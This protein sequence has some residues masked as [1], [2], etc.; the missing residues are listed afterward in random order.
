MS[1]V[2]ENQSSRERSWIYIVSCVVLGLVVLAAVLFFSAAR[3][4]TKA[5]NKADE[6]IAALDQAGARTPDRDQ[7]VRVLGDDGGATCADPNKALSRATLLA[8]L[9]NGATGPG[10]RPVIADS[11][12]VKGQLLIIQVYCPDELQ[13]FQKFADDLETD[14]VAG[15]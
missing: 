8:L 2:T 3:E 11:R 5:Q 10:A 12:A 6:L 4:T 1:T 9:S 7:V 13:D 14:D 15:S